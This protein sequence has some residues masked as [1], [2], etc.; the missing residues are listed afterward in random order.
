MI[1]MIQMKAKQCTMPSE[2]GSSSCSATSSAY[3]RL[4]SAATLCGLNYPHRRAMLALLFCK[5]P[6]RD[7]PPLV[8]GL[9]QLKGYR[10]EGMSMLRHIASYRVSREAVRLRPGGCEAVVHVGLLPTHRLVIVPVT[11][12]LDGGAEVVSPL[13]LF[14]RPL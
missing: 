14:V 13:C 8:M 11:P 5:I 7:M 12:D 6:V 10:R 3:P 1:Q 2:Q 4:P 9:R